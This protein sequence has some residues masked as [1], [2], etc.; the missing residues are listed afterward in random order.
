MPPLKLYL[1][2]Y[3][4]I[5]YLN[6]RFLQQY[7]LP[8]FIFFTFNVRSLSQS[9]SLPLHTI[10]FSLCFTVEQI[11]QVSHFFTA[12]YFLSVNTHSNIHYVSHYFLF[13]TALGNNREYFVFLCRDYCHFLLPLNLIESVCNK[14]TNNSWIVFFAAVYYLSL[15]RTY[16][17]S[18]AVTQNYVVH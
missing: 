15:C 16:F 10:L 13:R 8:Q 17:R 1:F 14:N 5:F 6:A 11:Y 2:Q 4:L 18:S 3:L 9:F 7:I 12:V